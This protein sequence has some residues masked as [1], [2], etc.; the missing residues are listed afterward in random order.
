MPRK[1]VRRAQGVACSTHTAVSEAMTEF[2]DSVQ[3]VRRVTDTVWPNVHKWQRKQAEAEAALARL[4]PR[5]RVWRE[6]RD[7]ARWY[8]NRA[9]TC[10]ARTN[11]V[12]VDARLGAFMVEAAV[13]EESLWM[14]DPRATDAA[15]ESVVVPT[16]AV[17]ATTVAA[18]AAHA[19]TPPAAKRP[20]HSAA[21]H[22]NTEGGGDTA[23]GMGWTVPTTTPMPLTGM[24]H[25]GS[26]G[27]GRERGADTAAPPAVNDMPAVME[28]A[29]TYWAARRARDDS[30][31]TAIA[32]RMDLKLR[33]LRRGVDAGEFQAPRMFGGVG[34]GGEGVEGAAPHHPA[35][36]LQQS[37]TTKAVITTTT[38]PAGT[39]HVLPA[40][41]AGTAPTVPLPLRVAAFQAEIRS[42]VHDLAARVREA[43]HLVPVEAWGAMVE[44]CRTCGANM[45]VNET[46]SVMVCPRCQEPLPFVDVRR[47]DENNG[48][49]RP[50]RLKRQRGTRRKRLWD[51]LEQAQFKET[52]EVARSRLIAVA[53]ECVAKGYTKDTLTVSQVGEIVHN[54]RLHKGYVHVVQIHARL[55]GRYPPLMTT[56]AQRKVMLFFDALSRHFAAACGGRKH[57]P[58]Y[59]WVGRSILR[60]IVHVPTLPEDERAVFRALIDNLANLATSNSRVK[61]TLIFDR[62]VAAMGLRPRHLGVRPQD[63]GVEGHDADG[64]VDMGVSAAALPWAGGRGGAVPRRVALSTLAPIHGRRGKRP[65]PT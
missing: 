16:T 54:M 29:E 12:A 34:G 8:R 28:M 42:A 33:A 60:L 15:G 7:R 27:G 46:E 38:T 59:S 22:T 64:D 45:E 48:T 53:Q 32:A 5:T 56:Q 21:H 2:V 39:D 40:E 14:K 20:R 19:T 37:T 43:F 24:D 26:G 65:R 41:A 13:L 25:M 47:T 55:T 61:H 23:G 35:H 3:E 36:V 51:E 62:M 9:H 52:G 1:R 49:S 4:P 50:R 44:V 30:A 63:L 57:F 11:P 31:T 10:E 58:R 17:A 6:M 18:A